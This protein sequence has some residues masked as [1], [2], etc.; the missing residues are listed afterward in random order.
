M[1]INEYDAKSTR[2]MLHPNQYKGKNLRVHPYVWH[3]T[4]PFHMQCITTLKI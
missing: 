1:G 4:H 3:F 2:K